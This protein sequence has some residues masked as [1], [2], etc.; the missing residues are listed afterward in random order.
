MI[1]V[2]KNIKDE[3]LE[4]C[5][6]CEFFTSLQKCKKCGCFMPAKVI[7]T[8]TKCPINKWLPYEEKV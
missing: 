4:I 5:K 2:P 8:N 3:R 6:T 7:L 1:T